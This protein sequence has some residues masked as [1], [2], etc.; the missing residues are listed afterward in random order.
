MEHSPTNST[1]NRIGFIGNYLPRQ[2]GIATFTTDLCEAIA[3]EYSGTTCIA[4]PVNDIE[5]GYAYPAR[6]RFELTEKDIDSYLRAADFLH[7]NNVDL[8]SLQH[9]YGIFGGRAGS[10]ILALLRELRMPIVTTLHT[11]LREPDP[12]QQRVLEE[13]AALSDRL[14]VMSKRGAEFLQ[15]IYHVLPEKIDLIPHGIPD[16]PFVDPSF[17]KDLFGVEGKI[18][19]LSFGLLSANKG[20]ENVIAALPAI[21]ARYPNVVYIIVGATHPHVLRLDGETYRLSLQWMA[22]EK[23]VEGQV[24]FYNRFVSPEELVQFIGAADIY[25]TPYL[26][27][28]QIVSGTLAYTLGAGKAVISTPY[29]YAEEMLA[30]ERGA[31]V[32]FRNPAALADQVIDLLDN[33]AKRHAMRK[34][35]YLCGRTMVW[36]QV[37]RR[38]MESFERAR[39]ERR[40]FTPPGLTAKALHKRPGELPP[41]KLDHLRHMADET[42]MLQHAI[43]TVPN[44][45][46]GYSTD[47]NARALMVSTLLEELGNDEALEFASRYLAFVWYAFNAETGRFR[48][49]MDY[50]RHWLEDSGSDDCHGRALCALGTVL[51]RSNTPAL[52]SMAGWLFERALPA[53][54]GTTSPRAWGFS[55]IGLHEYLQRFAGDRMAS[56]VREELAGRLLTLYQRNRSDQWRWYEEALTYCN[57]ALPHALL[58]CGQSMPNK[59]MTEAGLESLSWLADLQRA[60]EAGGHF[61]P[62]GSNGFYQ[63]GGKRARFDQ[64]PVEAQAMVSACLEAAEITGDTRWRKEARRAFEWFLG[65]NDLNLP[66]YDPMTGGCRDGLHPDRANENQGA[67]STLAFLQALLELRL[68]ENAL[69]SLEARSE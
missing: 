42:G 52:H 40:H 7:T 63:R 15:E 45:H 68:S 17:H 51:G 37:A 32:P 41:L 12:D 39:A 35:A 11:I 56:Q 65:R 34:R 14:V 66:I 48:N 29:W 36:P 58:L 64:Q 20:I 38:Y 26:N 23:G 22:Q 50:Q 1:I 53:I 21:L 33:E 57:A 19:L 61:V 44:Y 9:E 31:L 16:V 28:A 46:E 43:F 2:C 47:D 30:E 55:L 24:I 10:H 69:Q 4:L 60:D 27:P 13:V 18:V 54:L 3:A 5:T 67:E 62:I 8:V 25:I 59:A 6:V 49:F